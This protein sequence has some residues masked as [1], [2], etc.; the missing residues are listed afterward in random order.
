[1][2]FLLSAIKRLK[3]EGSLD[4]DLNDLSIIDAG[5]KENYLAMCKLMLSEGRQ[6]VALLDGDRQGESIESDLKKIC[7][8]ELSDKNLQTHILPENK[9]IEDVTVDVSYLQEATEKL[10]QTFISQGIRKLKDGIDV[11]KEVK[12]IKASSKSLGWVIEDVTK[13][14]WE[15]ED[16]MSKLSIAMNYEDLITPSFED[17]EKQPSREV[18][19]PGECK[20]ELSA[21]SKKL[22]LKGERSKAGGVFEEVK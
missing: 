1:M 21:I 19:L 20:K 7:Q 5:S 13:K 12:K 11:A 8:K 9:S 10:A 17:G 22:N 14:M 15:P 2:I 6:V 4:V 18:K 3:N 16:K